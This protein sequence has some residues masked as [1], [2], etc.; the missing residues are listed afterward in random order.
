VFQAHHAR[1]QP[2]N[3]PSLASVRPGCR[4]PV[5]GPPILDGAPFF[6]TVT[7]AHAY[8]TSELCRLDRFCGQRAPAMTCLYTGVRVPRASTR[9]QCVF[10]AFSPASQC[11]FAGSF[12]FMPAVARL[13]ALYPNASVYAALRQH[14]RTSHWSI[15][16]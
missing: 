6:Y 4:E 1:S 10:L 2:L 16:R 5:A 7:R 12:P 15:R 3:P 13:M 14:N 11:L 9:G 8:K